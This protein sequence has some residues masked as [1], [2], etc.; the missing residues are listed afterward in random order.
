MQGEQED[1]QEAAVD[2]VAEEFR[3]EEPGAALSA[4]EIHQGVGLT[5]GETDVEKIGLRGQ[6]HAGTVLLFKGWQCA[7][8]RQAAAK[9]GALAGGL[10]CR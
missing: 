5:L 1:D 4:D 6:G 9:G 10:L 2:G 7:A 3:I 8:R